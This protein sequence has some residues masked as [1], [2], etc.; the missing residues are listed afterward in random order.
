MCSLVQLE[1]LQEDI[2]KLISKNL[3]KRIWKVF[4]LI[5][6][7]WKYP[8]IQQNWN[9]FFHKLLKIHMI[10]ICQKFGI[11][12]NLIYPCWNHQNKVNLK[13]IINRHWIL[14]RLME[15]QGFCLLIKLNWFS[16]GKRDWLRK[17]WEGIVISKR[18][19]CKKKESIAFLCLR[20]T[21][22]RNFQDSLI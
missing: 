15:G 5:I 19:S 4:R 20:L 11:Q 18:L 8:N 16:K 9:S 22:N 2:C 6:S 13:V 7:L 10:I 14:I 1:H 12:I 17:L 3:N 21:N